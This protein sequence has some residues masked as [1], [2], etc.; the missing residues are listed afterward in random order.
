MTRSQA[1]LLALSQVS[2]SLEITYDP[3][4]VMET[5]G[6][7][8]RQ[9]KLTCFFADKEPGGGELSISYLSISK[10][11]IKSLEKLTGLRLKE[12]KIP[13]GVATIRPVV[14]EGET[15][16][17]PDAFTAAADFLSKI[18]SGIL[19]R[20]FH[21]I[22]LP[23]GKPAVYAPLVVE[24]QVVG[25]FG[26]W[27]AGL[28]ETDLPAISIFANQVSLALRNA[29]LYE[30]ARQRT[31][32]LT[33][34]NTLIAALSQVASQLEA[35]RD[36]ELVFETLG[37]GL[38]T[39][40]LHSIITDLVPGNP[41]LILRQ[42]SLMPEAIALAERIAGV[43]VKDLQ[44]SLESIQATEVINELRPVII[45]DIPS[46]VKRL[47]PWMSPFAIDQ[48]FHLPGLSKDARAI[49][50]PLVIEGRVHG[51][52]SILGENLGES[53]IPTLSLFTRQVG[54]AL[55]NARLFQQ[56]QSELLERT[57]IQETLQ[58]SRRD[59]QQRAEELATMVELAKVAT[60]TLDLQEVLETV[61]KTL[62]Q[63]TNAGGV[64]LSRWN[65]GAEILETWVQKRVDGLNINDLPLTYSLAE[66]PASR[67]VLE[68]R[69]PLTVY[70][71]D[72]E[73]DPAEVSLMQ[74]IGAGSL[75]MLP[76]AKG[77][78][79]IGLVEIDDC[80]IREFSE[81][82]IRLCQAIAQQAALAIENARLHAE[83]EVQLNRQTVL[84]QVADVIYASLDHQ[85]VLTRLAEQFATAID[86]TSVYIST[87][88]HSTSTS[89][90]IAEYIS[91]FAA[92]AEKAS[93]LDISYTFPEDDDFLKATQIKQYHW[94]DP[95]G[96][97][98][99]R[100]HLQQYGCQSVMMVPLQIRGQISKFIEL[101]ESRNRR[102]FTP[103]E[104]R[105]CQEIAQQAAIAI[106]NAALYNEA[107]QRL[108]EQTVINEASEIILD[109]L[110]LTEVTS[111]LT[112]RLCWAIDATSAYFCMYDLQAKSL[113]V[114]AEHISPNASP[115][116]LRSSLG[117]TYPDDKL[118]YYN[119]L[120]K[121][122]LV[123]EHVD[124]PQLT[125]ANSDPTQ[126]GGAKSILYIPLSRLQKD[127]LGV[128]EVWETRRKREFSSNE[129]RLCQAISRQAVIAVE[130]ARLYTQAQQE[131]DDR[132]QAQSQVKRSEQDYHGL[133]ENA[134]DPIIIFDPDELRILEV[135]QRACEIYG[136]S[137][138]EWV[139]ARLDALGLNYQVSEQYLQQILETGRYYNFQ[140]IHKRKN[141]LEM[142]M[143]VNLSLVHYQG[144][145]AIQSINRDATERLRSEERLRHEAFHDRLTGLPNRAL[146]L[147]RLERAIVRYE[148]SQDP[149]F[150]VI[151]LD[152]DRFK[153]VNDSKGH[154]VG[155]TLLVEVAMRLTHCVRSFD[156][157][158]RLGGDEFVILLEN[159]HDLEESTA[160]CERIKVKLGR[161]IELD[162]DLV[163]TS[164]SIG[165]VL[166][167]SVYH[168]PGEYLRDADIAM[169]SAKNG[170][171]G[172]FEVFDATMRERIMHRLALES[173][174]RQ[175]IQHQ[176]FI[177]QYMPI[178]A[179]PG[180]QIMGFEALVRWQHPTK[181]LVFP[182]DFIEIAEEI[183]M[184][185]PIGWWVLREAC[186]Q[187]NQW[188]QRF[189]LD[190]QLRMS[191]NLSGEQLSQPDLVE[192]V[193]SSL[194]RAGLPAECLSLEVTESALIKDIPVAIASL[195]DL[196]GL[197]ISLHLDDFGTG[198]SSLSYLQQFPM[199][200]I[201]IDRSFLQKGEPAGN[202]PDLLRTI[203]LMG[204]DLGLEVVAEGI[205]TEQQALRVAGL[206]CTQG[207][208]F[209]FSQPMAADDVEDYLA[210]RY[211][212]RDE[213]DSG[214]GENL[215]DRMTPNGFKKLHN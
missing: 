66:Y 91:P 212:R 170:G 44:L 164:A 2:T 197:G 200:A 142:I 187:L 139:G 81:D 9:L 128:L 92:S 209:L 214:L 177:L 14:Q 11:L 67:R 199:D 46:I 210:A 102:T 22:G 163:F 25:L 155:D 40:D 69:Q 181:G 213:G 61:I 105:L 172:R 31:V 196:K 54:S 28:H 78:A 16:F 182:L 198:Y 156:T 207:Q 80:K 62:S 73:A 72:P 154:S 19:G 126:K 173:D 149:K 123:V 89:T 60:S 188:R 36:P 27:G 10:K 83:T 56:A 151:F 180:R 97:L 194:L 93:H 21:F 162:G 168:T 159:I 53:D 193:G 20:V 77:E 167:D 4:V 112:E 189:R 90:V 208:G 109:S 140:T 29:R 17:I 5:V 70:I 192:Q 26:V 129:L 150:A 86:V 99:E 82:E 39:L 204:H 48:V 32:D 148:R 59:L 175:A 124:N 137:R 110:D 119:I 191:V 24:Q 202:A 157:V 122:T 108:R 101:W 184:I 133:F 211:N 95:S 68:S 76:L 136:F 111:R 145:Q 169:Y 33:R 183:G 55:E 179:L 141:G 34:A 65:E 132:K 201:K 63:V 115:E 195:S 98:I 205:E 147:D 79:V 171:R 120:Q 165:V 203:V 84:R 143:E 71:D 178:V 85:D 113:S 64:T 206:G 160:V 174:L 18:P 8:L 50:L 15:V 186:L 7:E 127:S 1:L 125:S 146:F 106:D 117:K 104:Q 130:K 166:S 131:I 152:L 58:Q 35:S 103:E 6:T 87:Y 116:E 153:N 94:D 96:P 190:R 47:F 118:I 12:Y 52:L 43:R 75:L 74:S 88:E 121:N 51:I 45:Q 107:Q 30:Q 57:L 41:H 215:Y 49:H 144:R 38:R 100:Q 23:P 176:E 158:A 42:T 135:N 3:L 185:I 161:P 114:I 134:H 138:Q 13:S 37:S